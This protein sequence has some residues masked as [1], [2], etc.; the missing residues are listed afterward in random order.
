MFF[1]SAAAPGSRLV[2]ATDLFEQNQWELCHRECRRALMEKNEPIERFQLLGAM[3]LVRLQPASAQPADQFAAIIAAPGDPQVTAIAAY[4]LGRLQWQLDRPKE[5]LDSLS[6]AFHTT[7]NKPLFLR[8]ACS[9]FLLFKEHSELEQGQDALI[10]QIRT[11]RSEWY[12]ALFKECAKPDP[13]KN[14]PQ[15]PN[16]LIRFYRSQISPA[17]G[18]RCNLEPSCS[19]YF[20]QAGCKH[21]LKAVPMIADRLFR[22]PGVNDAKKDPVVVNGQIRYR[23]PLENHDF[24][25]KK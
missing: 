19:E 21:G 16:W 7:T 6:L 4:E 12:G 2:L 24:W 13:E 9:L 3:S 17:I 14:K 18:S 23:D 8:S 20:H 15:A 22:E 1:F 10:S 11:S 25:M 5:A